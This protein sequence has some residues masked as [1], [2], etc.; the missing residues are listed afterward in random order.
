MGVIR[1]SNADAGAFQ[2]TDQ[3]NDHILAGNGVARPSRVLPF[4]GDTDI[5][6]TTDSSV[7][8]GEKLLFPRFVVA[9]LIMLSCYLL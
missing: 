1:P 5:E 7:S 8:Y 2:R 9:L 4:G 6:A 3:S